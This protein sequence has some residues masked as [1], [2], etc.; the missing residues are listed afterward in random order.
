MRIVLDTDLFKNTLNN[1]K[2]FVEKGAG[3]YYET[4]LFSVQS[5]KVEISV[6]NYISY[7]SIV[8]PVS[9]CDSGDWSVA[10]PVFRLLDVVSHTDSPQ[11]TMNFDDSLVSLTISGG[12]RKSK[13]S[14]LD[15]DNF[16]VK[17]RA[18]DEMLLFRDCD[19]KVLSAGVFAVSHCATENDH[20]PILSGVNIKMGDG[21]HVFFA[22]TDTFRI[23]VNQIDMAHDVFSESYTCV[24]PAVALDKMFSV[25]KKITPDD[26]VSVFSH[27]NYVC[28]TND[29]V[30]ITM[31]K[32]QGD[33]PKY[34]KIYDMKPSGYVSLNS[35]DFLEAL[36]YVMVTNEKTVVLSVTDNTLTI[37]VAVDGQAG[38][39]TV[40]VVNNSLQLAI[41][42]D[43]KFL[44]QQILRQIALCGSDVD[45]LMFL[46]DKKSPLFMSPDLYPDYLSV[47]M[48]MA[49]NGNK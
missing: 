41:T 24:I 20:K 32:L 23:A 6:F 10:I 8:M 13:V 39:A 34:T 37:S 49:S 45:I 19:M 9:E 33:F 27:D 14:L 17:I 21:H 42:V 38:E 4:C 29:I 47:I 11:V 46:S 15:G 1:L 16:P 44:K 26:T 18:D 2:G 36:A 31:S 3:G 12:G 5:G 28:F 43:A 22:A 7:V 35:T 48:P 40:D 30:T 25:F